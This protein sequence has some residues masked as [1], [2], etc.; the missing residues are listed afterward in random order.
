MLIQ[1]AAVTSTDHSLPQLTNLKHLTTHIDVTSAQR[2]LDVIIYCD[3]WERSL[4]LTAEDCLGMDGMFKSQAP[5][6]PSKQQD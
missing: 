1:Y 5:L 4:K 3:A 6:I 2:R